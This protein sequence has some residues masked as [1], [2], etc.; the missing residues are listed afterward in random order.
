MQKSEEK[1]NF[2]TCRLN[3]EKEPSNGAKCKSGEEGLGKVSQASPVELLRLPDVA[4]WLCWMPEEEK[5]E[6]REERTKVRA[7]PGAPMVTSTQNQLYGSVGN[8]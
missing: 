3:E 7:L 5:E 4:S 1:L 2:H 6:G 8:V